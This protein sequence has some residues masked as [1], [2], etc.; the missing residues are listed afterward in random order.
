M[1]YF[2]GAVLFLTGLGIYLAVIPAVFVVAPPVM[3]A[4]VGAVAD[5][6]AVGTAHV[7]AASSPAA[8]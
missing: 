1:Q 8:A 2:P 5:A 3:T 7:P 6:A 4:P